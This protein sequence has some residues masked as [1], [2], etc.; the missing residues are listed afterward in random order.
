MSLS[1]SSREESRTKWDLWRHR[2]MWIWA[3]GLQKML[4]VWIQL[5]LIKCIHCDSQNC[6]LNGI[7]NGD[8]VTFLKQ[9]QTPANL[10]HTAV[11]S[12]QSGGLTFRKALYLTAVSSNV[13]VC[14]HIRVLDVNWF[15]KIILTQHVHLCVETQ[16]LVTIYHHIQP[17][18]WLQIF[19]MV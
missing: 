11:L 1:I 8:I 15:K 17:M 3:V 19:H 5:E 14:I 7:L 4:F 12:D 10:H 9:C 16:N 2:H 13:T 18:K 6:I